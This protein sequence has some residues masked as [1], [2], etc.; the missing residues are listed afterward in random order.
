[1]SEQKYHKDSDEFTTIQIHWCRDHLS[2]LN[3]AIEKWIAYIQLH[4]FQSS[5]IYQDDKVAEV[6][7]II[8]C[9]ANLYFFICMTAFCSLQ[10]WKELAV[11]RWHN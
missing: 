11:K 8:K 4:G 3:S 9:P 6:I 7:T 2:K 5:R 10:I 1:L